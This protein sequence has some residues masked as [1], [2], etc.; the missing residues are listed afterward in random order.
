MTKTLVQEQFGKT[1]ASYLDS[2]PHARGESLRALIERVAPEKHWRVLDVATGAG[3]V[4]YTF[5]PLVEAVVATDV[6]E[7]MLQLVRR[8]AEKRQLANIA[9][10]YAKAEA[11]P[12]EAG[13]FNAVIT[14]IAPHH[15]EDIPAFLRE[16]Q[17]VLAPGGRLAVVD[18]V[19]PEG[20][21]GDY[22]NAFERFRD[23]SHVRALTKG[24]WLDE[25]AR[26]GFRLVHQEYFR[27]VLDF[28]E[29]TS[30]HGADMQAFLRS[31]LSQCGP[32]P[33]AALTPTLTNGRLTFV[34]TE[35]F[36]LAS[37]A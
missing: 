23:P 2:R 9:V 4:A 33:K 13:S 1:A 22:I 8:E 7:E 14:R 31:M 19:V 29:W 34:L 26:A 5:A 6:T 11:L 20:D 3:H 16:A 27:K 10:R 30:R 15:F 37:K 17:R 24:V 28:D 12:F 25:I 32:E 36:L 21:A 35:A 18:N